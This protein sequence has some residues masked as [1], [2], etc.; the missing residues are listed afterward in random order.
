M[1]SRGNK[2]ESETWANVF[3]RPWT[4]PS[5]KKHYDLKMMKMQ[6]KLL[7]TGHVHIHLV[8]SNLPIA[9]LYGTRRM[10]R[11]ELPIYYALLWASIFHCFH[12]TIFHSKI[13]QFSTRPNF[14]AAYHRKCIHS[15]ICLCRWVCIYGIFC[16]LPMPVRYNL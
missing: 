3:S 13:K 4:V 10:C 7:P 1:L 12:S 16:P 6:E 9:V 8:F 14:N 5:S 2:W 11:L 15:P